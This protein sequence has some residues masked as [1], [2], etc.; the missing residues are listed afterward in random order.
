MA[1]KWF[2]IDTSVYLSDSECLTRFGNNDII[3]PLKVLEEIDKHKKRQDS[4]GFHARQ[5]IKTFDA[6][7]KQGNLKKGVRIEKGKGLVKFVG[8]DEIDLKVLPK[9]LD[10]RNSDHI[11]LATA[12]TIRDQNPRRKVILVSRDINLRVIAQGVDLPAEEYENIKV[13]EA[14]DK[15]YTGFEEIVVDDEIIDRFYSDKPV[16]LDQED[17]SILYP[18]Q[19][20]M[21][22]SSSNPKKTCLARFWNHGTRLQKIQ[23]YT[24]DLRW[25]I[26]PRNKEQSFA[27]DLLYNDDISFVTLGS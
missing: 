10:P 20:L 13:V 12:L 4:V 21:L 14:K 2:V 22:V 15:I 1:K 3:V 23:N 6:L 9:D 26:V 17:V 24:D 5:I 11:I 19:F 25:N 7:R 8:L 27:Y 18:N 16:F